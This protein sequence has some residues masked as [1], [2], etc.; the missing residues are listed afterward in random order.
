MSAKI[1]AHERFKASYFSRHVPYVP[2]PQHPRTLLPKKSERCPICGADRAHR[3]QGW[4]GE[5]GRVFY[6]YACVTD[7]M[8]WDHIEQWGPSVLSEKVYRARYAKSVPAPE[9]ARR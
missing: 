7:D 3:E 4:W 1:P 8:L 2:P 9:R 6:H 5:K